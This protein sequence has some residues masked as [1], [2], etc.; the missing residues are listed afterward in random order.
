[1]IWSLEASMVKFCATFE[2]EEASLDI[3]LSH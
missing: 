1:M 3:R 2:M